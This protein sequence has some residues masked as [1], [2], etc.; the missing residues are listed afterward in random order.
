VLLFWRSDLAAVWAGDFRYAALLASHLDAVLTATEPMRDRDIDVARAL[1]HAANSARH[2]LQVAVNPAL[3][4]F[5][6]NALAQV[7]DETSIVVGGFS[8]ELGTHILLRIDWRPQAG[9]WKTSVLEADLTR[10]VFIGDQRKRAK[11]IARQ[12]R[13]HRDSGSGWRMEPL[14]AIH[15]A[16]GHPGMP[17]IGGD[18]QLAKVYSHGSSRAYGIFDPVSGSESVR[19][20]RL[21]GRAA[22]ELE[23][24]GLVVDLSAWWLEGYFATRHR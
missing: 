20:T 9:G 19:G 11:Q 22:Q 24:R 8:I 18:V 23:M 17:T 10:V 14:C 13:G 12:A 4:A 3:P 21:S 5:Q 7:P 6:I 16:C 2:H 1:R 15:S